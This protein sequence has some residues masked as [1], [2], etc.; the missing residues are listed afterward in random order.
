MRKDIFRKD[1]VLAII[2][3]FLGAGA[4]SSISKKTEQTKNKN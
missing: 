2:C 4:A 1:M 3:L